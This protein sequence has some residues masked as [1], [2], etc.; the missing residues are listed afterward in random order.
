M[1][2]TQAQAAGAPASLQ[3]DPA[4]VAANDTESE[5]GDTMVLDY[6]EEQ[7]VESV[8]EARPVPLAL[9][10]A[11]SLAAAG[12][13]AAAAADSATAQATAPAAAADEVMV[14][15]G[16]NLV[17]AKFTLND[18]VRTILL[19][20][21]GK[22]GEPTYEAIL[23]NVVITLEGTDNAKKDLRDTVVFFPDT[24]KGFIDLTPW[25]RYLTTVRPEHFS[26]E[27]KKL[28][29]QVPG[30]IEIQVQQV[31]GTQFYNRTIFFASC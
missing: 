5:S 2:A 22:P 7:F 8:R 12:G 24:A 4:G 18:P 1:Q 23:H 17:R 29:D 26:R 21:A 28:T 19:D 16:G 27:L 11:A 3:Q 10:R 15:L 14:K 25:V 13:R 6:D 20:Y 31:I 30:R 9:R